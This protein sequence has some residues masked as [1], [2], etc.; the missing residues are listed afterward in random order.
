MLASSCVKEGEN[1]GIDAIAGSY[2]RLMPIGNFLYAINNEDLATFDISDR[3]NPVLMD[4]QD[5]G[6]RIENL[7]YQDSILFIGSSQQLYIFNINSKGIPERKKSV[8]YFDSGIICSY[9][10]VIVSGNY[11]YVT[12]SPFTGEQVGNCWREFTISE[13]RIYDIS[14]IEK[15]LLLNRFPMDSPKGLAIDGNIL[16]VCEQDKGVK[17]LDV[18][19]K[20][21]PKEIS[22][23]TGFKTYDV[24]VRDKILYVVGT[25]QIRE[26]DYS[27]V[28]NIKL[29]SIIRL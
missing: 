14:K 11:A 13:L 18:T 10:P 21:M 23:L 28:N 12:L 22:S 17:I 16:F 6:F 19:D 24:I 15:P 9:D 8:A 25:D 29:I 20:F 5:V 3:N 7:F 1:A 2:S 4:R 27:D 26:Y